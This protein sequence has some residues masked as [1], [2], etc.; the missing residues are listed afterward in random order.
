[1]QVVHFGAGNIGRG[2][3]G[4][5]LY[6]SGFETCFVDVNEELVNLLNEKKEYSVE[7]AND[8]HDSLQVKN[9]RAINSALH[10]ELVIKEITNADLVTA[11][12]GPNVLSMIAPLLAEGLKKRLEHSK[13]PLTII[14]CENMIG[15]SEFLKKQVYE[16]L[17]ENEVADFEQYFSFPNAAVD[18]IVP[19]QTHEDITKVL[20]EPFY[21]WVVDA[22][23][24]K[25]KKPQ[26]E[27]IT[28]VDDLAPYIE[29]KLFT[30][31]TGHAAV[32]YFGYLF[33]I[34]NVHEALENKDVKEMTENVLRETGQLL[35]KKHGFNEAEHYQYID[36]IIGRFSNPYISDHV[37]RVARSP[38]RKLKPNDRFVGPATQF[39]EHFHTVPTYL[40][41]G[42]A[43][44]LH[45]DYAEDAEAKEIQQTIHEQGI[46]SAIELYT[47][48]EA[49]TN[50]FKAIEKEYEVFKK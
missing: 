50:L 28:F 31:N 23:Q 6:Q 39:V 19:N 22:S 38:K 42:I 47:E 9:V 3:I 2:F 20:V 27:G 49:D 30:V 5:L 16:Q 1:M 15:G 17:S 29:R 4:N 8:T 12:V 21:E 46:K 32:A 10:P 44:A 36:K 25:G 48:L 40:S 13:K 35:I 34:E 37:T 14:A 11:A 26:V 18:R 33:G 24:I 45:Y 7:L 41:K 43:A